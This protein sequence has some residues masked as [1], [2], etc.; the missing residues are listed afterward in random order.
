[1]FRTPSPRPP[2]TPRSLLVA[3]ISALALVVPLTAASCS[4]DDAS[5]SSS[6]TTLAAEQITVPDAQVT[7]GLT[8]MKTL[9]DDAATAVTSDAASAS[10]FPDQLENQWKQ[11]EG[12]VKK[13]APRVYIDAEDALSAMDKAIEDKKGGAATAA[14]AKFAG[15]ADT[16]LGQHP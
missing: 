12:T 15:V 10:T 7:T 1:M 4:G 14:S 9:F 6:P 13:N 3:A 8:A 11:I 5:N 16:Y 2:S